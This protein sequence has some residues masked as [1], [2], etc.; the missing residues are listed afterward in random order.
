L[1]GGLSRSSPGH[2]Q[3]GAGA[4]GPTTAD[5]G[6]QVDAMSPTPIMTLVL[7]R[8]RCRVAAGCRGLVVAVLSDRPL[9]RSKRATQAG[10]SAAGVGVVQAARP[11]ASR[12]IQDRRHVPVV[13][14]QR[15]W[16]PPWSA[17]Q[18]HGQVWQRESLESPRRRE[19]SPA[20]APRHRDV[21]RSRSVRYR[22]LARCARS[23][24]LNEWGRVKGWG[25]ALGRWW[26]SRSWLWSAWLVAGT[27]A[28]PGAGVKAGG[29]HPGGVWP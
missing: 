12:A 2:L 23:A 26:S 1:E 3:V 11:R 15:C 27:R 8:G 6:E 17:S 9:I 13:T 19:T 28:V 16:L 5:Q 4:L 22:V 24:S 7:E 20:R 21:R 25:G 29:G 10:I 14:I 18:P